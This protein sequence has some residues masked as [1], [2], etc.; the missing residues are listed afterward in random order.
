MTRQ[1]AAS[2]LAMPGDR[3]LDADV[4]CLTVTRVGVDPN[5][6]T[7]TVTLAD[8]FGRFVDTNGVTH[9]CPPGDLDNRVGTATVTAA[10]TEATA[11]AWAEAV[12]TLR[13]WWDTGTPVRLCAAPGR[14][15]VLIEG[16]HTFLLFPR[17]PAAEATR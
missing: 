14:Y 10:L 9:D 5:T 3:D 15:T 11:E 16:R 8:G 6:R 2:L 12:T 7:L 13:R 17:Q 4:D 1:G